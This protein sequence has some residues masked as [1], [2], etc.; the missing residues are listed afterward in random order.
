MV[1]TLVQDHVCA[2]G[3]CPGQLFAIQIAFG[4]IGYLYLSGERLIIRP[5]KLLRA[6]QRNHFRT[7]MPPFFRRDQPFTLHKSIQDSDI[8]RA[9]SRIILQIEQLE[10]APFRCTQV[11]LDIRPVQQSRPFAGSHHKVMR[12]VD[13][14]GLFQ[15]FLEDFEIAGLQYTRIFLY[16]FIIR[17]YLELPRLMADNRNIAQSIGE[18]KSISEFG[19]VWF[20]YPPS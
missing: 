2:V 17:I 7:E 12:L 1:N 13:H 14:T 18:E 5:T 15:A 8:S 16:L 10:T 19:Y 4:I 9:L 11:H 6:E 20:R 3:Q